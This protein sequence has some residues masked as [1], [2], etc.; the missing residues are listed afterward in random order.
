M[1]NSKYHVFAALYGLTYR[2][3]LMCRVILHEITRTC[4]F[5]EVRFR[6][7]PVVYTN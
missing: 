1:L 2:G 6:R 7:F 5:S 3:I 4:F